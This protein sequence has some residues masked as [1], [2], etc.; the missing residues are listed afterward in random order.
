MNLF[1]ILI[2]HAQAQIAVGGPTAGTSILNLPQMVSNI[3]NLAYLIGGLLAFGAVVYGAVR[4]TFSGGN[5]S[6]QSDARDQLTQAAF[7]LLLLLGSYV[8]LNTIS[9]NLTSFNFPSLKKVAP[10]VPGQVIVG[11]GLVPCSG[12]QCSNS[13]SV[14]RLL[15]NLSSPYNSVTATTF[16]GAHHQSSCHFGGRACT[17]GGHAIDW[18]KNALAAKGL[19][20]SGMLQAA[21]SAAAKAGVSASCR[22]ENEGGSAFLACT[23]PGANHVHCN[24]DTASCGCN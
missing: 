17:D 5:P 10:G 12:S 13:P 16:Q 20:L 1:P 15:S 23:D 14:Q 7:G 19:N 3:Y 8:V 11:T 9:P 21:Q 18:G 24:V 6:A 22:C 4:Y 2:A